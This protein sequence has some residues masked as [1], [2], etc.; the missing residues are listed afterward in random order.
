M[1]NSGIASP[2]LREGIHGYFALVGTHIKSW[3]EILAASEAGTPQTA[4]MSLQSTQQAAQKKQSQPSSL[5]QQHLFL[6]PTSHLPSS[7]KSS[8]DLPLLT[9]Q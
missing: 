7:E 6:P 5:S 8:L 2:G 4:P 9:L 1:Q 3:E